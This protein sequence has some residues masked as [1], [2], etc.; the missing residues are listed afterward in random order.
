MGIVSAM[1]D[2][3][4]DMYLVY[5]IDLGVKLGLFEQIANSQAPLALSELVSMAKCK[6]NMDMFIG[7]MR[8]VQVAG[9]I[10]VDEEYRVSFREGWREALTDPTSTRYIATLPRCYIALANAFPNFPALFK[11]GGWMNWQD[12]G[13]SVVEDVSADGVRAAN[14]FIQSAVDK[15][16]GLGNKLANGA[17]V[18]DIGCGAG[19]FT[20]R[21]AEAFPRSHFV[22]IDPWSEAIELARGHAKKHGVNKCATFQV[23]CATK[24]PASVA[25]IVILNDVLHEMDV[26]LRLPA[27]R[28]IHKA[29]KDNGG[30]FFSDPI[31][32]SVQADNSKDFPKGLAVALFFEQPFGAKI[33]TIP[34][35]KQ[36]LTQANF[37]PLIEI[38]SSVSEITAYVEP[39]IDGRLRCE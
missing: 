6:G 25:D 30:M 27:L 7:W 2:M 23:L 20:I 28:A 18:Y 26:S 13:R 21:L 1:R 31:A 37:G 19:H 8:A 10:D 3:I 17:T 14:F 35:L 4:A 39:V 34:E 24:L 32:P 16:R 38:E 5:A 9:V 15:V 22:G 11:E 12:L 29:L 36:M 33:L